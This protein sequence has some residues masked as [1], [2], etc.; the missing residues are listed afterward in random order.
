MAQTGDGRMRYGRM[1]NILEAPIGSAKRANR[2][3][4]AKID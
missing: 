4:G 1:S 2:L 3:E